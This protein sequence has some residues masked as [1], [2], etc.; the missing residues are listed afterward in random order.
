MNMVVPEMSTY[1]CDESVLVKI[2]CFQSLVETLSIFNSSNHDMNNNNNN[3]DDESLDDAKHYLLR[4][5]Q[6]FI[7]Y[8][9]STKDEHYLITISKNIGAI[10]TTFYIL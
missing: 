2:A 6:S 10:V 4:K 8:G 9:I 7:D 1:L 3:N 5:I